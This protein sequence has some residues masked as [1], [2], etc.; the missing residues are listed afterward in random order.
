[1]TLVGVYKDR[2]HKASVVVS[3][4]ASDRG[5]TVEETLHTTV[6]SSVYEAANVS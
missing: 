2:L 4:R 1:V 5:A 3:T 6:A